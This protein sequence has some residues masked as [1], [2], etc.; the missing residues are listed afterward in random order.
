MKFSFISLVSSI[1]FFLQN[2]IVFLIKIFSG[3]FYRRNIF[4]KLS[5]SLFLLALN[6]NESFIIS[7]RHSDL[8]LSKSLQTRT[9]K[10]EKGIEKHIHNNE[11]NTKYNQITAKPIVISLIKRWFFLS[12]TF[13]ASF[14]SVMVRYVL[15]IYL[16]IYF[17]SSKFEI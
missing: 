10:I 11:K 5:G 8:Q 14:C 1:W 13:D 3:Y 6:C 9:Q 2:L 4:N 15:I 17:I 16:F 7:Y 12:Q